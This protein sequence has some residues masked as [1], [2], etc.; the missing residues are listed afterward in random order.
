MNDNTD[1][2][3]CSVCNENRNDLRDQGPACLDYK[4]TV[5]AQYSNSPTLLA[6]LDAIDQKIKVCPFFDDFYRM[7]WNINTAEGFGLDIWGRIVGVSRKVSTFMGV[8]WGFNEESLLIARPYCDITGYDQSLYD[9]SVPLDK[10]SEQYQTAFGMFRDFQGQN[11]DGVNL[12]EEYSFDDK[13]FRK[14]I[15][16]K[17]YAN[18]SNYSIS[19]INFLLMALLAEK[20]CSQ[21]CEKICD[22]NCVATCCEDYTYTRS[23]YIKDNLDMSLTIYLNWLPIKREV[24]LIYNTALL[25]RPSGVEFYEVDIQVQRS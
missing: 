19:N 12:I 20:E 15:L 3:E 9:P 17:A 6:L 25:S 5:I 14:L 11:N 16:A 7:V 4:A 10:Q 8:F 23:I 1:Q 18:I 13:D 2:K 21:K 22:H 24:A